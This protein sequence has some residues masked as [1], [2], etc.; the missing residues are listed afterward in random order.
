MTKFA[1]IHNIQF[2]LY[3]DRHGFHD[4]T[5]HN[6]HNIS[7][8]L[9]DSDLAYQQSVH[10]YAIVGYSSSPL[11]SC[12]FFWLCR[13][14]QPGK[15]CQAH[16]CYTFPSRCDSLNG[17][18]VKLAECSRIIGTGCSVQVFSLILDSSVGL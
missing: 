2:Y 5:R 15:Q 3:A 6:F 10:K 8:R 11:G 12:P 16:L 1:L 4:W 14:R 9:G 13:K 7:L 17:S 18:E